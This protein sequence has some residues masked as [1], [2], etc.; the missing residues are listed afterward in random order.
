MQREEFQR[1]FATEFAEPLIEHGFQMIGRGSSMHKIDGNREL[2]I[3]RQGGRLMRPGFARSVICFRHTFLRP[4]ASE[5]PQK[6]PIYVQDCPRK[7]TFDDFEGWFRPKLSYR[8]ENLGRW[9]FHEFKYSEVDARSAC[10]R[11]KRLQ[12]T[13]IERILPWA[14]SLT[15]A[16][17]LVQIK[18]FGESAW[19]ER[20]WI[21]DYEAFLSS[22]S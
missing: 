12:E 16:G 22:Q 4:I 17:E 20:R 15:E 9:R 19:C 2:L 14:Q 13:V 3:L 1:I 21:E 11:L 7:V 5:D 18:R 6:T 8:P 10:A